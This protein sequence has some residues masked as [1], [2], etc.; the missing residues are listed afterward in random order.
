MSGQRWTPADRDRL[1]ACATMAQAYAA[2]PERSPQAIRCARQRLLG[3]KPGRLAGHQARGPQTLQEQA[4]WQEIARIMGTAI[5]SQVA[6][7]DWGLVLAD[8][9][10][11]S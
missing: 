9:R 3:T 4:V 11:S 1:R 5:T 8:L 2:F 10:R 6:K 7:V